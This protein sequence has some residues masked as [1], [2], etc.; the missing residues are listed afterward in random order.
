M[1]YLPQK[2]RP[3]WDC[4]VN[5][6]LKY[7][8]CTKTPPTASGL[9]YALSRLVWGL[10]NAYPSKAFA[11]VLRLVLREVEE[12]F[13]NRKFLAITADEQE[14]NGDLPE[15]DLAQPV[16]IKQSPPKAE[17]HGLTKI[18]KMSDLNKALAEGVPIGELFDKIPGEYADPADPTIL[19]KVKSMFTKKPLELLPP[20]EATKKLAA[21]LTK[22]IKASP[23]I[24]DP[25]LE[26][27]YLNTIKAYG[28]AVQYNAKPE[29]LRKL[30][31]KLQAQLKRLLELHSG[32]N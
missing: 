13:V 11:S 5:P 6:F 32:K 16:D 24:V 8:I 22:D 1:P 29:T 21:E 30:Q 26:A 18:I 31:D 3:Y 17:G 19:E 28:L 12:E 9:K 27:E 15:G 23:V 10:F 20:S 2:D 14:Q 7:I 4:M 25:T